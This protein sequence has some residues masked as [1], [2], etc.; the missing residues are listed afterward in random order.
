MNNLSYYGLAD[1]RMSASDP[2]LPV[3]NTQDIRKEL[4][5]SVKFLLDTQLW[6]IGIDGTTLKNKRCPGRSEWKLI[7]ENSGSKLRKIARVS[8]IFALGIQ[9]SCPSFGPNIFMRRYFSITG[10]LTDFKF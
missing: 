5:S 9:I 1:S 4:E 3:S 8:S 10:E 6:K 7:T 2:D